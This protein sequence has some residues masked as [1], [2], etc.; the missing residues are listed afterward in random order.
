MSMQNHIERRPAG[1]VADE[2]TSRAGHGVLRHINR[3]LLYIIA[4]TICQRIDLRES[5]IS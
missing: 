1:T 5:C 2:L 4:P 3:G